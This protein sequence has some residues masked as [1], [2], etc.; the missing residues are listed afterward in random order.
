[1]LYLFI[2]DLIFLPTIV[3]IGCLD[4]TYRLTSSL[5]QHVFVGLN[6]SVRNVVSCT[7]VATKVHGIL[8]SF[9][10]LAWMCDTI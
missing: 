6:F 3:Q 10:M 4:I 7:Y 9:V 5:V 1:M 2:V 8:Q